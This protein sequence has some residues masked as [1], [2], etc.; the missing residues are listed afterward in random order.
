[1]TKHHNK[2]KEKENKNKNEEDTKETKQEELKSGQEPSEAEILKEEL[3][4]TKDALLRLAAEFDNYKRRTENEIG[5]YIKYASENLIKELLPL[6]DDFD[7]SVESI[8]KGETKDFETLKAG[9]ISIAVKFRKTLESQ[10]LKEINVLGK[11]FSVDTCD[12]LLQ[13][14]KPDVPPNTVVEVVEKGYYLKDKVIRH[15]KVLVSTEQE[16]K[17]EQT[18]DD[19]A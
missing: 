9:L 10:G 3:G 2:D 7:R 11:E 19:K 14:P 8:E 6:L 1:M 12:A 13:V 17:Q 15:S 18:S 5:N 4:K 16:N